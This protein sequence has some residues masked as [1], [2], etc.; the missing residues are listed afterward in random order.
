MVLEELEV[1]IISE[2]NQ[3]EP[4]YNIAPTARGLVL[5]HATG[6]FETKLY[7]WGLVPSWAKDAK[8]GAKLFNARSETVATTPSFRN[9]F[10]KRRCLV[11]AS[12]YFEW[13]AEDGAKQPYFLHH[14]EGHLMMFAGLWEGWRASPDDDWLHTYTIVTGEPGKVSADIH[15]RQPVILPPDLWRVWMTGAPDEASAVLAAVPEAELT[16][17]PVTKAV[18]SSRNQDSGLVEPIGR[19]RPA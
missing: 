11:P 8:G 2:I 6:G 5:G 1:D 4:A 3:R 10:R 15:Q 12:G 9:A 14:P 18:N 16:Y 7:R 19:D 13:R 17:H